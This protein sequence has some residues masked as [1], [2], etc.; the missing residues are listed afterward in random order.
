VLPRLLNPGNSG[1]VLLMTKIDVR[2]DA[3]RVDSVR[4]RIDTPSGLDIQ[5]FAKASVPVDRASL[6]EVGALSGIADSLAELIPPIAT[7]AVRATNAV[8]GQQET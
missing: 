1:T 5:L 2:V 4:V 8:Q 7:K 3:R 6:T